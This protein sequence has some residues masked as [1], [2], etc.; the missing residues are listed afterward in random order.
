MHILVCDDDPRIVSYL[1]GLIEQE[2][3]AA[4]LG[5]SVI[6]FLSGEELLSWLKSHSADL[7]FLDIQLHSTNGISIARQINQINPAM[8]IIYV[9][10]YPDFAGEMCLTHFE[11]FL[12]KPIDIVK[13][14][15]VFRRCLEDIQQR[16]YFIHLKIG[17]QP[18]S[19]DTRHILYVES[20]GRQVILHCTHTTVQYYFKISDL[21][22]MLPKHFDM[23][24]KCYIVNYDYVETLEKNEIILKNQLRLPLAQKKAAGFRQRYMDYLGV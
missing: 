23:P 20:S 21:A 17:S 1:K 4:S 9:T 11:S 6:T 18:V 12:F 10:G 3:Q 19:L 8:H 2:L 14:Q 16:T 15:T 5:A 7:L 24:H 13:F 22:E